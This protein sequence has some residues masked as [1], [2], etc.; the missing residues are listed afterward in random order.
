M[1]I[2]DFQVA[3]G[4]R[5]IPGRGSIDKLYAVGSLCVVIARVFQGDGP[6]RVDLD[7][8]F[9]VAVAVDIR[10]GYRSG[11]ENIDADHILADVV[12]HIGDQGIDRHRAGARQCGCAG[13]RVVKLRAAN[14]DA[15]S[16][17]LVGADVADDHRFLGDHL[18]PVQ[19]Q[20]PIR[21]F[22]V[23]VELAH[24]LRAADEIDGY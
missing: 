18:Q 23:L 7:A 3:D 5:H 9:V 8:A 15:V 1:H 19:A 11:G 24:G 17:V 6:Q 2:G 14:V 21:G 20:A 4:H 12:A 16:V 22:A 13:G 10:Q